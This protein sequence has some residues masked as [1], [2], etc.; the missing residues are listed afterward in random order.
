MIYDK[1]SKLILNLLTTLHISED[2][3]YIFK[4][5]FCIFNISF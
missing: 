1:F 2:E 5:E 4:I 3:T